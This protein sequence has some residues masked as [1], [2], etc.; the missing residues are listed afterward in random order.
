MKVIH[1]LYLAAIVLVSCQKF[2]EFKKNETA[3][4]N[5]EEK[6]VDAVTGAYDRFKYIFV[7]YSANGPTDLINIDWYQQPCS[8]GDDFNHSV[9]RLGYYELVDNQIVYHCSDESSHY[10]LYQYKEIA[11]PWY[12]LYKTITTLN[13]IIVHAEKQKDISEGIKKIL[14]EAYLLRAYVYF[15]LV[16]TYGEV[17][18]IKDINVSYKVRKST[19]EEIYDFIAQDLKTAIDLLPANNAEA[20]IPN[21]TPHVGTAKVI[22]AEVYLTRAGYPLKQIGY[23]AKAAEISGNIIDSASYYGYEIL[24]DFG[25]LWD[26]QIQWNAETVLAMNYSLNGN[27]SGLKYFHIAD[28]NQNGFTVIQT[29]GPNYGTGIRFFNNYPKSYRKTVTFYSLFV[30]PCYFDSLYNSKVIPVDPVS[31][32]L[33]TPV[34]YNKFNVTW[35]LDST[36]TW[37]LESPIQLWSIQDI[38]L[39]FNL[40]VYRYAQTLLTFAEAKARSGR[41]DDRA[42]EAVNIIRRRAHKVDLY[43]PSPYDLTPGLSAEQFADSVVWERAWELCA[44]PEGRWFDLMRLEMVEDLPLLRDENDMQDYPDIITKDFYFSPIPQAEIDFDPNLQ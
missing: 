19:F 38:S 39:D 27:E 30:K 36:I 9:V 35:N 18:L 32:D 20:R 6:I 29:G 1:V 37:D 10:P 26:N 40:Y 2:E 3:N 24:P 5:S 41:L 31:M 12:D 25:D 21:S 8:K 16:R 34:Y 15:R 14:G 42:Y 28:S 22:L 33:C 7:N 17:P 23:Y 44:E 11:E 13:S 43:S 4:F